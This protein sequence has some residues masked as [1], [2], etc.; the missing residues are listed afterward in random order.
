MLRGRPWLFAILFVAPDGSGQFP[1][2]QSALDAAVDGDEVHLMAGTF[3]GEGN[4]GLDWHGKDLRIASAAN[5]PL[6]VTIETDSAHVAMAL[7]G[8]AVIESISFTLRP[9]VTGP[10]FAGL[11]YVAGP[12]TIRNCVFEGIRSHAISNQFGSPLIQDCRFVNN[13]VVME[14]F[15]GYPTFRDCS[16]EQNEFTF[17][18]FE[19]VIEHCTF[20]QSSVTVGGGTVIRDSTL[21]DLEVYGP[22]CVQIFDSTI[23][24]PIELGWYGCYRIITT[25]LA[26]EDEPLAIAPESWG[27]PNDG[28]KAASWGTIKASYR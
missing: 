1:T 11:L 25:K 16:F 21:Q 24:N 7:S 22:P 26:E 19:G 6:A 12:Q 27:A 15:D 28:V 2:I 14:S 23:L 17:G 10:Y 5:D 20:T 18:G 3:T 4:M 13:Q 8:D 9:S